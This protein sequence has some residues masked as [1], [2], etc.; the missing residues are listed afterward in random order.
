MLNDWRDIPERP[1][2]PPPEPPFPRCPVC[3]DETDTLYKD[4]YGDI[5]GCD[6]CVTTKDAWEW[7]QEESA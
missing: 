2:E 7:K 1:L 6:N 3:G 4:K 5:V